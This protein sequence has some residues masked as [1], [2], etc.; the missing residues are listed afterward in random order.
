MFH[1]IV[2]DFICR[3]YGVMIQDGLKWMKRKNYTKVSVLSNSDC[4]PGTKYIHW[5]SKEV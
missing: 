4:K 5:Q 3:S 1:F 2:N